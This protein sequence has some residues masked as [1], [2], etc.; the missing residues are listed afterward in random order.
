MANQN[1]DDRII[2][3]IDIPRT[4]AIIENSLRDILSQINGL[5]IR[6]DE[7]DASGIRDSI[8]E[9]L[10]DEEEAKGWF[11]VDKAASGIID[12]FKASLSE[13]KE[14]NST[15]T[16]ISKTSQ[17]AAGDLKSLGN[18][19]FETA[20]K[21]GTAANDYLKNVQSMAQEG[22]K[23]AGQM[24]E[25]STLVQSA[26]GI[27]AELANDYVVASDAAYDYAGNIEK[28]TRLLDGQ[29][30]ATLRSSVSMEEFAKAAKTAGS[31]LPDTASISESGMTAL[32]G[33][34]IDA[35]SESG[36]TVAQAVKDI[37]M[38]L[39]QIKG[40]GGFSGEIIDEASLEKAAI[41]MHSLGI[42]LTSV[43]NG[44]ETLRDPIAVLRELAAAYN[45]LPENSSDRAG[46]LSDIGGTESAEVLS[47]I[48]SNWSTVEKMLGDYE[49]SSGSLMDGASKSA[50]SLD[51]SLTRLG[52]TWT[53][54]VNNIADSDILFAIVSGLNLITG[55]L[56]KVTASLGT[57]GSASLAGAGV[58]AFL[59]KDRSKYRFCPS[60]V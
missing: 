2:V 38:N 25:L 59:Q 37:L 42:A 13:L 8:Q 7:I 48:L 57:L 20:S 58:F 33:A 6:L 29:N 28:L 32:L 36:E 19:A 40:T 55:A 5:E 14:I 9:A 45:A 50:E 44:A 22:Y 31:I 47:G 34:G 39:Q 10:P 51:G 56:N 15:L 46:I 18:A 41:R 21:Y 3:S 53:S 1:N 52:N 11:D 17:M 16:E 27:D 26:R 49:N 43:K 23:N 54:T 35:S 60:W 12:R 24:A 4:R 30:Q